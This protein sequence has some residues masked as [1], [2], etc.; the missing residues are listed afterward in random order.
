VSLATVHL[1]D[2]I[3]PIIEQ[4]FR[5]EDAAARLALSLPTIRRLERAGELR[6]VRLAGRLRF[7]ASSIREYVER[8]ASAPRRVPPPE[9]LAHAG[10]RLRTRR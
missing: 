1:G 6:A 3:E 4:Y 10:R 9:L 5:P 8:C 2:K 7:P